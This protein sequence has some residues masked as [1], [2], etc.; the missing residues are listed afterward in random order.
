MYTFNPKIQHYNF[1]ILKVFFKLTTD[2][3]EL[4]K[5]YPNIWKYWQTNF[6]IFLTDELWFSHML[7]LESETYFL[8]ALGCMVD[9]TKI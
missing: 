4:I 8:R 2:M 1:I 5:L 6:H 7:E 3:Y 9:D